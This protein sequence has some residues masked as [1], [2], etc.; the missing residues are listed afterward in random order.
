MQVR[1]SVDGIPQGYDRSAARFSFTPKTV[2]DWRT[3][4]ATA[5]RLA[6]VGFPATFHG[7]Y[8]GL[9]TLNI[10]AYGTRGDAD[11]I[12][13]EIMDGLKGAAYVDDRQVHAL[14]IRFPTRQLGPGGGVKTPRDERPGADITIDFLEAA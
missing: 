2:K 14:T 9:V 1:F 8:R 13:K 10:D 3:R 4:V 7:E 11:N 12:A 6:V 5:Y